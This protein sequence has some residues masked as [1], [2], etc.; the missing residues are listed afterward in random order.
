MP[1]S[2]VVFATNGAPPHYGFEKKFGSLENY[3]LLRAKEAT[4]ALAHIPNCSIQWLTRPDGS[5]FVDQRLLHD[6]EPA[7]ASLCI[8]ARG[9]SPDCLITHAY[10]GGHIDHDTCSFIASHAAA[11]LSLDRFEF[12]LYWV[13]KDGKAAVQRF[14]DPGATDE[15][16][17]LTETEIACKQKMLAEY[18][19][20]PGLASGFPPVTERIRSATRIDF[21]VAL[22]RDYAYRNWRPRLWQPR[23]SSK[24][25]LRKFAEFESTEDLSD[26]M[27][28][29]TGRAR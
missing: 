10:E 6:I 19:T 26:S 27:P 8:I 22:C 4:D 25:L 3:R 2:M 29:T 12:P 9:F 16:W 11:A 24:V 5:Y 17:R 21:S 13:D 1:S 20:Q 7:L 28:P 14:R 23:A 18:K 15:E